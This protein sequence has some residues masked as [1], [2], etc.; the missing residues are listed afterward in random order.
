M[1]DGPQ[2]VHS[3]EF[4]IRFDFSTVRLLQRARSAEAATILKRKFKTKFFVVFYAIV[5]NDLWKLNFSV[6]YVCVRVRAHR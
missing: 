2:N 1:C 3:H 4:F 6:F 5:V